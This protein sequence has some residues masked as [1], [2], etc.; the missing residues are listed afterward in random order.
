MFF[1]EGWLTILNKLTAF[2]VPLDLLVSG[3]K[4]SEKWG[5]ETV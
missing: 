3:Q 1:A 5:K 4:G 2:A